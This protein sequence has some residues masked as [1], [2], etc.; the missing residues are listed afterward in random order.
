MAMQDEMSR[1]PE[2]S[3][4]VQEGLEVEHVGMGVEAVNVCAP[5]FS[6]EACSSTLRS[7]GLRTRPQSVGRLGL[8]TSRIPRMGR[9]LRVRSQVVGEAQLGSGFKIRRNLRG[10]DPLILRHRKP[11]YPRM[12]F[13]HLA[14][15]SLIKEEI[16]EDSSLI[17]QDSSLIQENN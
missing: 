8:E 1:Q 2:D 7:E 6:C 11:P 16:K 9:P 12:T 14:E 10:T 17:K 15:A 13:L 4:C 5:L 3:V